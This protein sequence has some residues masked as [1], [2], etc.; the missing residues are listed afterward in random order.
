MNYTGQDDTGWRFVRPFD[1]TLERRVGNMAA[2]IPMASAAYVMVGKVVVLRQTSPDRNKM[3][4]M[5]WANR[6]LELLQRDPG[7]VRRLLAAAGA[8]SG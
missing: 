2:R 5:D 4:L 1:N 3:F 6:Q 7:E 8:V